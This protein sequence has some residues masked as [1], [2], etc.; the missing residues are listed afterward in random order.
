MTGHAFVLGGTGQIGRAVALHLLDYGWRVT[1]SHRG[2]R[3]APLELV[4]YGIKVV[5]VDREKPRGLL[6]AIAGGADALIDT[7]AYTREHADQLLELEGDVGAFVVIS[8]AS[9]YRDDAGRT[10]DEAA[11]NGFPEFPKPIKETQPT[12]EPGPSTY[13]TQKVALE[14]AILDRA[15]RPATVLRPCAI[16]GRG[17]RQPR[18]WWFVKRML[19]GR[20]VIPLAY[21]GE[22]RFHTSAAANIAALVQIVL[23]LHGTRVLNV[24]DPV[25]PTVAE[26]GETVGE[27]LN[28]AGA[29]VDGSDRGFPPSVGRTPWSVPR[30]F[31]VDNQAAMDVGYAPVPYAD[32]VADTCDWLAETA[33]QGDWRERFPVLARY[34]GELFDYSGE[35]RFFENRRRTGGK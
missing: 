23:G 1:I 20:K 26:I 21:R 15:T 25:A 6:K 4:E 34:P 12:V 32:A 10:L 31:V 27:R 13:S 19:D 35:D 16:H 3:P 17:S 24:T 2:V 28:Y 18:E 29:F 30:P 22:S 9:V 8:S 11:E 5:V 7:T 14:R 33:D